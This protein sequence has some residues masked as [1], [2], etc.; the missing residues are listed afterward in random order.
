MVMSNDQDI[1]KIVLVFL[2][3]YYVWFYFVLNAHEVLSITIGFYGIYFPFI[4]KYFTCE[5]E[6]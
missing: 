2:K 3:K 5:S 4:T 1:L 6:F